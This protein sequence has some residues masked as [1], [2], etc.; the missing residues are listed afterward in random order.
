MTNETISVPAATDNVAPATT[1]AP[2][3]AADPTKAH[4]YGVL[5]LV[6]SI[7]SIP[8]GTAVFAVAGIVLGF[9]GR[10]K[11][12][13]NQTTSNWAIIVGF[14]S[15]FGWVIIALLGLALFIPLA[16]SGAWGDPSFWNEINWSDF[17]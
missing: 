2:S 8:T 6:L 16:L 9:F 13:A 12:T 15:L 14:V 11:D 5:G 3:P 7:L 4:T 17:N 10:S 1:P